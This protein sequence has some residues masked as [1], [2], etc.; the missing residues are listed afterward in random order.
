MSERTLINALRN[1]YAKLDPADRKYKIRELIKESAENR[2]FIA[3]VLPKFYAEA[4]SPS[5]IAK[6]NKLSS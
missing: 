1:D 5:I 6:Q 3:S 2:D 4:C